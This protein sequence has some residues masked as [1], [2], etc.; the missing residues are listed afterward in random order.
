M[1]KHAKRAEHWF[2][3]EGT[4]TVYT[5]D[6]K[7]TDAELLGVYNKFDSLHIATS[8]WHQLCNESAAPLKIVEIQ[9][10]EDCI[11]EDIERRV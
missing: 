8:D 10:G 7:T 9:Y 2:I 11:E 5:L 4:A 1:Q 3:A 6:E